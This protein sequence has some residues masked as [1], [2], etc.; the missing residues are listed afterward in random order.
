MM[1]FMSSGKVRNFSYALWGGGGGGGEKKVTISCVV[2]LVD[3]SL[4]EASE[5]L[6]LQRLCV[7]ILYWAPIALIVF[8][9]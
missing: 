8:F 7:K 9:V 2:C 1:K 4:F 3:G 5:H 6:N